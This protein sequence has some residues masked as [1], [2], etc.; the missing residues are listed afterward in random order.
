MRGQSDRFRTTNAQRTQS[1]RRNHE[2]NES[3]PLRKQRRSSPATS[4]ARLVGAA[5]VE[6][7][8][9]EPVRVLA[10]QLERS[11]GVRALR[12]SCHGDK[13]CEYSEQLICARALDDWRTIG[14]RESL[15]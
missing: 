13:T 2:R 14:V 1:L 3:A 6:R 10:R 7:T 8:R 11:Q 4:A 15:A 12:L 5:L 9:T